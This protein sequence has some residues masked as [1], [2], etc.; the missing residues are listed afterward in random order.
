M[1]ELPPP[2]V[3]NLLAQVALSHSLHVEV[4]VADEVVSGDELLCLFVMQLK[5]LPRCSAVQLGDALFGLLAPV[6]PLVRFAG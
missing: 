5:P 6:A 3:V 2:H 4:F 1:K